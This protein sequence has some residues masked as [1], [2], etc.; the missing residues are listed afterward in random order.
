MIKLNPE[1]KKLWLEGLRNSDKTRGRLKDESGMCCLGVLADRV[2]I[3]KKPEIL[4]WQQE[5]LAWD[6]E[7]LIPSGDSLDYPNEYHYT[8]NL[9]GEILKVNFPE[10][11]KV[12][13]QK[14][15]YRKST[16]EENDFLKSYALSCTSDEGE[17]TEILWS[18][19][20]L[21]ED[22]L[23]S[24]IL[25]DVLTAINDNEDTFDIIIEFIERFL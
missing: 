16:K 20:I 9:L 6:I 22:G 2:L 15:C 7:S 8:G 13:A 17:D 23:N 19:Y 11:E 24:A 18:C 1:D 25:E 12:L 21:G 3:T 14:I 4:G 10:I 5:V